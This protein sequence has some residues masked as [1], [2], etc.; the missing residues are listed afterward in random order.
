MAF[1][2]GFKTWCE[3]AALQQRRLLGLQST[4]PLDPRALARYL[5]IAIWAP[6]DVPGLDAESLR[7]LLQGD[8]DA[9]SAVTLRV[10]TRHVIIMNSSHVGGRPSSDL[11]H[12]LSH[13]LIGHVP[14]RVDITE[15]GLLVLNT[16]DRAQEE[17]A[18]WLAGCLLLP[19]VALVSIRAQSVDPRTAAQRYGVS[20]DMLEY[21]RRMTGVDTQFARA[22]KRGA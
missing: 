1:Q 21:R 19:R 17:E 11:A 13:V 9:W 20:H 14:A 18:S 6:S 8:P 16:F 15:D 10:G 22:R 7:I 5:G 2:R 4:A 12:E 3:N